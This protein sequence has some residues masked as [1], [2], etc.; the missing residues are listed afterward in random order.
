MKRETLPGLEK[1]PELEG[2]CLM[3]A[4]LL[5]ISRSLESASLSWAK[6]AD[7]LEKLLKPVDAKKLPK[8]DDNFSQSHACFWIISN[9][10][11]F[12]PMILDALE[13]WASFSK[14]HKLHDELQDFP[15][16][17]LKMPD[18]DAYWSKKG[19][20]WHTPERRRKEMIKMIHYVEVSKRRLEQSLRRF[21]ALRE[22]AKT[23]RDGVCRLHPK[24]YHRTNSSQLFS[25]AS[26]MKA[27]QSRLLGEQ[28]R[29]LG[30]H[31]MLLTY[32]TIFYLPLAF[33]SV[34][35]LFVLPE[36]AFLTE[37][38]HCGL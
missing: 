8:D 24:L 31:V 22:Q 5:V 36:H 17:L 28:S 26:V 20:S 25:L 23:V 27:K 34:S 38:S 11:E 18:F 2:K 13:Q 4:M 3:M 9:I 21:Q 7:H 37:R 33:S 6:I 15:L 12:E 19:L 32:V 14:K 35:V 16:K 1:L 10:E 30:E 29:Q